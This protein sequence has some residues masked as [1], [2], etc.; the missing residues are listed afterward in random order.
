[1]TE[2]SCEQ[3]ATEAETATSHSLVIAAEIYESTAKCFDSKGNRRKAGQYLTIA[4]DFYLEIK[5]MDKA[6]SC[7]GKAIVR[8]LMTEDIE[9]AKILVDKG[10]EY[11]FTSATYQ[12]KM[13]LNA[14]ERKISADEENIQE[15]DE[16]AHTD[17]EEE[18]PDIKILP[19]EEE[20]DLLPLDDGDYVNNTDIDFNRQDFIVP[21]LKTDDPSKMNSF[22]VLAAVSENVRK[23]S[24]KKIRSDAV[25]KDQRGE[26]KFLSPRSSINPKISINKVK[27]ADKETESK[28]DSKVEDTEHLQDEAPSTERMNVT[29]TLDLE[30][31]AKTEI[32][33]EYEEDLV[34]IE[35]VDRIPYRWEVVD[36]QTDF[37][38]N[39]RKKTKEGTVFTWKA[40]KLIPGKTGTIEYVL[41]KRVERSIILRKERQVVV[42]NL[43]HSLHQNL[44]AQLNFVNTTGGA[45]Q[46][47]L[48]E[49][50]IPPEL[51]VNQAYSPQKIRPVRIPTHDS[52]LFRWIFSNLPP[53]DT[54]S[55]NYVF[56]EKPLTRHYITEV[57]TDP[58]KL[59]CNKISQPLIDS[60]DCEYIWMYTIENMS[61]NEITLIDRIPLDY[62]I[63]LVDPIHLRP[64]IVREKSNS[65]LTWNLESKEKIFI[66]IRMSGQES[67]TPLSPT[68]EIKNVKE[69]QMLETSSD[70]KKALIDIRHLK[71]KFMEII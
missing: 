56:K 27:E 2:I 20:E 65:L 57:E 60:F 37:E 52:T 71:L 25:V 7:Y 46:E 13:A 59:T 50:V 31:A 18:L 32:T 36:F 23:K 4:G 35:V 70:S 43:Y 29:D 66:I 67:F 58:G 40:E 5:K 41:R 14:L 16:S 62:S 39:N 33:N 11:G 64:T 69:I 10:K 8:H 53:G 12:F 47:I 19:L 22:A 34:D 1:M 49:D 42:L 30:Y 63:S 44:E 68:I 61:T 21:Q 24:D 26:T 15:E 3:L 54:F 55:S 45:I 9:T 17:I 48:I 6:A 51:V 38:L 28:L